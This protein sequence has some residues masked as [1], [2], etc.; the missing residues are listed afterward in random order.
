MQERV[1]VANMH[2][3]EMIYIYMYV[4]ACT[5]MYGWMDRWMYGYIDVWMYACM[6]VC[7]YACTHV[8][9][10]ACILSVCVCA[11]VLCVCVHIVNPKMPCMC[12]YVHMFAVIGRGA[13]YHQG[14]HVSTWT[15]NQGIY[16]NFISEDL[17]SRAPTAT[18]LIMT[19][20]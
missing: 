2:L 12:A 6:D 16:R 4:Y 7:M 3:G 11:C 18:I 15:V 14:H 8:C 20:I 1:S 19:S 10:H 5:Y 9:M 17:P 13:T